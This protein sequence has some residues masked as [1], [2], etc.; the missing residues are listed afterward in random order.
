ML[1]PQDSLPRGFL[2]RLGPISVFIDHHYYHTLVK[3]T[4][5]GR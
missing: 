5:M 4:F 2:H 1:H 3:I